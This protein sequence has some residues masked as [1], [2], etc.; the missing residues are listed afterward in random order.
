[1]NERKVRIENKK[2]FNEIFKQYAENVGAEFSPE[3]V[4]TRKSEL[5]LGE[6]M[7]V[8]EIVGYKNLLLNRSFVENLAKQ[9][10]DCC[11]TFYIDLIGIKKCNF[12]KNT[13]WVPFF[14]NTLAS[15]MFL[16]NDGTLRIEF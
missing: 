16:E 12:N 3:L 5:L 10:L 6:L 15:E 2:H 13:E 11:D 14:G 1:M 8:C 9:P 7:G 4:L